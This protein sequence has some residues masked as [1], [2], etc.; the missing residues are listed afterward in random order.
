MESVYF[1]QMLEYFHQKPLKI[2]GAYAVKSRIM[3]LS[4]KGVDD[5]RKM[6]KVYLLSTFFKSGN[7]RPG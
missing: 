3:E 2:P 1:K 6:I 7:L 5:T 4:Q